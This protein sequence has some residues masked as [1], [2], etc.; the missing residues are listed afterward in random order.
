MQPDRRPDAAAAAAAA[1][2]GRAAAVDVSEMFSPFRRVGPPCD[3]MERVKTALASVT[4]LPIRLAF[5][6]L[7]GGVV[8]IIA[9]T[10]TAGLRDR[11][12]YLHR[13]LPAWRKTMLASMYPCIRAILFVTFG[14]HRIDLRRETYPG[15]AA[16]G[17]AAPAEAYVVVANHLG[18]I[19]IVVLL[20]K[21]RGSFVARGEIERVWFVGTIATAL[22]C[23]FV[24]DGEPFT[25][26]LVSRVQT[27][28][29]CHQGR[30]PKCTGC[31][32]C[33][34]RLIIFPEGTT[35][36]GTA[37]IPF[38]TGVFNA[39]LPVR[40]VCIQFPFERFN[41]SWESIRFREHLFRTLTQV[42]NNVVVTE[43]PPYAPSEA[44][45][46]DSRLYAANVQ[47]HMARV[48]DQPI[49]PLNR[50]HKLLYHSYLRGLV[51]DAHEIMAS[52]AK[53]TAD[54]A[55]LQYVLEGDGDAH[56]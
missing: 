26:Q 44:E 5:L 24:R 17:A 46:A 12:H 1:A 21:Y 52:A 22:Q 47:R 40:P 14:V 13:A 30:A 18:Y 11:A 7:A 50:R 43:L 6:A 48:L 19:D 54:D 38:R 53:L 2:P 35:S 4:L 33:M 10:A 42:R 23:L 27:T 31:G 16:G 55:L 29:A 39:G 51:T 9:L 37:M 56:V 15:A 36:N 41:L 34:N 20:A 32:S 28:H 8:W 49:V 25:S 3:A 45:K